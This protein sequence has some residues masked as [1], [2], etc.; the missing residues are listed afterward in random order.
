MEE[1][2][3]VFYCY[4]VAY[5]AATATRDRFG[6][7]LYYFAEEIEGERDLISIQKDLYAKLSA[8]NSDV[9]NIVILNIVNF[10][11]RSKPSVSSNQEAEDTQ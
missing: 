4:Y 3:E 6:A 7:C 10:G 5:V 1:E 8:K 9:E 2:L 11:L